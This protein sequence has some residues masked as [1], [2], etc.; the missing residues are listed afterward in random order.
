MSNMESLPA[1]E[2][3]QTNERPKLAV[4]AGGVSVKAEYIPEGKAIEGLD[5]LDIILHVDGHQI[6]GD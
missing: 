5:T 4:I 6:Y 3:H 1:L 2:Q